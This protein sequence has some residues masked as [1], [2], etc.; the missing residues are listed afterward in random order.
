LKSQNKIL[1]IGHSLNDVCG[2]SEVSAMFIKK[3]IELKYAITYL[4]ISNIIMDEQGL[5]NFNIIPT[6]NDD[7]LIL[8][9]NVYDSNCVSVLDNF[10]KTHTVDLVLS[11]HDPWLL[12]AIVYST[13]RNSFFWV[14]Y[15][16]F[17]TDD[18]PEFV[19][20][21]TA[22]FPFKDKY[23]SLKHIFKSADMV[24][25]CSPIGVSALRKLDVPLEKD[26]FIYLGLEN[27]PSKNE[28]KKYKAFSKSQI[29][30]V[31]DD[32]KIIMMLG[33]NNPR[34]RIDITLMAFSNFLNKIPKQERNNY[35][36]YLHTDLK[37]NC[38][39]ADIIEMIRKLKIKDNIIIES[40]II[41]KETLYKRYALCDVF[42]SL[43]GA[44]GFGLP[45]VEALLFDKPVI[46]TNCSAPADYCKGFGFDIP[47][48]NYIYAPNLAIK[49]SI[50]NVE[51]AG[52]ALKSLL[53]NPISIDGYSL[54]KDKFNW[55]IN[56]KK[57]Y[58]K[59]VGSY[60]VWR[61]NP[62]KLRLKI[63]RII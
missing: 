52:N 3:F 11:I 56:F 1:I 51:S 23:K 41:D 35:I 25:P 10:I 16:T 59:I 63:K 32:K 18:Y 37:K 33:V 48:E 46:Y 42:M 24:I 62:A 34:K 53:Y 44:E 14:V 58:N 60:N 57:F 9:A 12:D 5:K 21:P 50:A 47:V 4:N 20:C 28:I 29:F 6:N 13:Y 40:N 61:K 55:D 54:V 7:F 19:F 31:A 26:D 17:E 15:Q 49:I 45:F 22:I 8:N 30:G 43:Y 27:I 36:F 38:N 39:G 2:F